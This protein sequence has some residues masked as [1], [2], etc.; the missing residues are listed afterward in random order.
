MTIVAAPDMRDLMAA[1][2]EVMLTWGYVESAIL[3]RMAITQPDAT[4]RTDSPLSRWRKAEAPT[5]EITAL[6]S[7]I[8]RLAVVRHALAHGLTSASVD[9]SGEREPAVSC[10]APAGKLEITL[11]TLNETRRSLHRLSHAIRS[12]PRR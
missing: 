12:L 7:E 11:S 2:G 5:P 8:D 9:P 6:L 3:Y 4:P 1:V 10:R